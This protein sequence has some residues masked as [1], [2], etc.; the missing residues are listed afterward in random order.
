MQRVFGTVDFGAGRV[1]RDRFVLVSADGKERKWL[2][3]G[4]VHLLYKMISKGGSD[5]EMYAL[6]YNRNYSY[7][8][9][10]ID[11]GLECRC[12]RWSTDEEM[13]LTPGRKVERERGI[14]VPGELFGVKLLGTIK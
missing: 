10:I 1:L 12:I 9:D 8:F 14:P 7:P 4:K 2:C 13:D 5:G 3:V 11:E 6:L